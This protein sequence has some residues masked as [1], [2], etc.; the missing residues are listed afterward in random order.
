MRCQCGVW[1]GSH[2]ALDRHCREADHSHGPIGARFAVSGEKQEPVEP[3]GVIRDGVV[4]G[5]VIRW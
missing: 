5:G 1:A 3:G 2:D 4:L